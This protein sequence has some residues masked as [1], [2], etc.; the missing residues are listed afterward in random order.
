MGIKKLTKK[1][2]LVYN[3]DKILLY[4]EYE[5]GTHTIHNT[6]ECDTQEELDAKVI[7]LGFEIQE[8]EGI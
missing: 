6:F 3:D 1:F 2:R 8:Q 5:G 4:G 7:E